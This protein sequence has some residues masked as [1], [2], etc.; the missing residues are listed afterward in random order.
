ML[1]SLISQLPIYLIRI[2]VILIAIGVHESA[3]AWMS[4][5][6]GDDTAKMMG[7]I[8]LNPLAHLDPLGVICL[9]FFGFGWAAPVQ[10]NPN[11]YKNKKAGIILSSLAGPLSNLI[12][13]FIGA[14]FFY[15]FMCFGYEPLT[16]L[17]SSVSY[18][19]YLFLMIFMSLNISMAVFNLIPVPPLDGSN[20]LFMFLPAKAYFALKK[21][22]RYITLAF[23]VLLWIGVLS[24]PLSL[25]TTYIEEGMLF[26]IDWIY[27][28]FYAV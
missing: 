16:Q 20:I 7:R 24:T 2:P 18:A 6:L 10:I 3:H 23:L 14:I 27:G 28:L 9:I 26:I 12:L 8:T 11:N 21:A 4:S 25:A 13:G 15:F 17:N 22:Q 19:V 5:K 1:D